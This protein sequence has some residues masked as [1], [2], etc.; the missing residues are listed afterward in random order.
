MLRHATSAGVLA[1]PVK[2]TRFVTAGLDSV[3]T[4]QAL[5]P[6]DLMQLATRLRDLDTGQV[7]FVTVPVNNPNYLRDGISHMLLDEPA[8][9]VVFEALRNDEPLGSRRTSRL[10]ARFR[11]PRSIPSSMGR[12][13]TV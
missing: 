13:R 7:Q 8:A 11:H 6:E 12:R 9:E 2:L 3:T 4:D 5:A 10:Q 1:D